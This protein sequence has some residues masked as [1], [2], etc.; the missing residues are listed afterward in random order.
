MQRENDHARASFHSYSGSPYAVSGKKM[1]ELSERKILNIK[2]Y[3]HISPNIHVQQNRIMI[4]N[5][6]I[7]FSQNTNKLQ[8]NVWFCSVLVVI[9]FFQQRSPKTICTIWSGSSLFALRILHGPKKNFSR[10]YRCRQS[11]FPLNLTNSIF[12]P[13]HFRSGNVPFQTILLFV[14]QFIMLLFLSRKFPP[15]THCFQG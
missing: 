12:F 2:N 9:L 8:S 5:W 6:L 7:M 14:Y 13:C 4:Y 1:L 10:M 11:R 15:F 3:V